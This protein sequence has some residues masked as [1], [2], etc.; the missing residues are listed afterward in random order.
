MF[1]ASIW[2]STW[3]PS[4]SAGAGS[5]AGAQF[6]VSLLSPSHLSISLQQDKHSRTF[7]EQTL[8]ST[9]KTT[10]PYWPNGSL[11]CCRP[12]CLHTL[13]PPVLLVRLFFCVSSRK[14]CGGVLRGGLIRHA[15]PFNQRRLTSQT[16]KVWPRANCP[17]LRFKSKCAL[18][19]CQ[20]PT[21]IQFSGPTLK[22]ILGSKN[23]PITQM[24][25]LNIRNIDI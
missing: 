10:S 20:S 22:P 14:M 17:V 23:V 16:R 19:K 11:H 25:F 4:S 24:R 3:A 6:C 12:F 13:S 5:W 1:T 21:D 15:K 7:P 18:H 2:T 9:K 8:E